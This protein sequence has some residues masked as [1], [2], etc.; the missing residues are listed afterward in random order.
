[1]MTKGKCREFSLTVTKVLIQFV[2][3]YKIMKTK[4]FIS[5]IT[6]TQQYLNMENIKQ[7]CNFSLKKT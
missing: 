6:F 3:K 5:L 7:R 4:C 1:M 2:N